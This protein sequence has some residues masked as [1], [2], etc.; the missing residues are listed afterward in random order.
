MTDSDPRKPDLIQP[1][2]AEAR[3]LA[4]GLVAAAR[5]GALAVKDPAT[6]HPFV[7]RVAVGQEG[8]VPLIL[9]SMLALHTRALLADPA[10]A[11][12][13]GEPGP[14][15]DPMN[16]PRLTWVARAEPADKAA[17]RDAWLAGHPKTTL[18]Y[19]FPDFRLFRLTP[20]EG[21]LNGG[22]ARAYRL[23]PADLT[24]DPAGTPA[25]A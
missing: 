3:A 21:H 7:T 5:I 4:R 8:G 11:L 17:L 12:L 24:G 19:D 9:V 15:G 6:G 14:K 1:T 20:V 23:T 16:Q 13:L 10:C 18:Y 25:G 2:D 22:F